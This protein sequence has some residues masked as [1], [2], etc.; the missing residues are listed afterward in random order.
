MMDVNFKKICDMLVNMGEKRAYAGLPYKRLEGTWGNKGKGTLEMIDD[1]F[2]YLCDLAVLKPYLPAGVVNPQTEGTWDNPG[3]G[4]LEMIDENFDEMLRVLHSIPPAISSTT[5]QLIPVYLFDGKSNATMTDVITYTTGSENSSSWNQNEVTTIAAKA[6]AHAKH[7]C[8]SGVDVDVPKVGKAS[9]KTTAEIGG[10]FSCSKENVKN[11][12]MS[13]T[14]QT[15]VK[16]ERTV[17][18]EYNFKEPIY[19][20]QGKSTFKFA[21]GQNISFFGEALIQ[22]SRPVGNV[23]CT[24]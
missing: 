12:M 19:V 8:E 17:K 10:S 6:E 14:S 3:K 7:A 15:H 21:D 9:S 1:N 22:S 24:F 5:M 16:R 2:R 23:T 4:T 20:Y 11:V 13:T 18:F